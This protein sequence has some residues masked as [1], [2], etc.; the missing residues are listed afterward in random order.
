MSISFFATLL[1]VFVHFL[2]GSLK[3]HSLLSLAVVEGTGLLAKP[4]T[5]VKKCAPMS[6]SAS[7]ATLCIN[8]ESKAEN[9]LLLGRTTKMIDDSVSTDFITCK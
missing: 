9:P 5:R 6:C 4:D 1:P 8:P 2:A 7:F 3:Y